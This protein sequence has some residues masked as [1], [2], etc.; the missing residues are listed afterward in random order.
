MTVT[1]KWYGDKAKRAATSGEVRGLALWGTAVLS[2]AKEIVPVGDTG[3]LSNSGAVSEVDK[4]ARMVAVSF[5]TPYAVRQH[6]EMGYRHAAGRRAKYLETAM[7][8][9]REHG[10]EILAREIKK[11]LG[12]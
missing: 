7:N 6:E 4:S 2:A 12:G 1:S 5:D 9:E 8:V 11:E 10:L 3:Q